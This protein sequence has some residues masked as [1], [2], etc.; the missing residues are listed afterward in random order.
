MV[1]LSET[2][3]K[4]LKN[5]W[6]TLFALKLI[7]SILLYSLQF[8][9]DGKW[10]REIFETTGATYEVS[11]IPGENITVVSG[12]EEFAINPTKILG[13]T[14]ITT[15]RTYGRFGYSEGYPFTRSL[16]GSSLAYAGKFYES[17]VLK[18][19]EIY[20]YWT[21][22]RTIVQAHF[23]HVLRTTNKRLYIQNRHFRFVKIKQFFDFSVI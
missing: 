13:L 8:Q 17:G 10:P 22:S 21:L 23:V 16:S 14:L 19:M 11:F 15:H 6:K 4:L 9:Y 12:F 2:L 18:G 7:W 3:V 20:F 5:N 1:Y